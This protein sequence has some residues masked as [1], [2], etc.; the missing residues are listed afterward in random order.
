MRP[1][2]WIG[3][4]GSELDSGNPDWKLWKLGLETVGIGMEDNVDP[5]YPFV[6]LALSKFE[7]RQN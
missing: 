3:Q 1:Y 4:W 7:I 6:I 5:S 2:Y